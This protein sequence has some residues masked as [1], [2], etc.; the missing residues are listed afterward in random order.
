MNRLTNSTICGSEGCR[1]LYIIGQLGEGGSERQL[2]YLLREL[3]RR[4]YPSDVL[5][6]NYF[7]D[8]RYVE[9]IRSLGVPIHGF[10]P[11]AS[12]I[13]KLHGV[14]RLAQ[15]LG[16]EVIHS[17]SFFTNFFAYWAALGTRAIALGSLRGDFDDLKK[18][19]GLWK[20]LLSAGW[21][22]HHISNSVLSA[23]KARRSGNIFSPKHI[24]VV[25]N[26]IDLERFCATNE[27]GIV[28]AS[29]VGIGS[30]LPGKRWDR[31]LKILSE[32]KRRGI[33]C[34]LRIA[35]DGPE[36]G[37]LEKLAQDIGIRES[38][39]FIG[40][41]LDV[42]GLLEKS[43]FLVHTSDAEGCPNVVMEAMACGR[44]VI[45]TDAGDIPLLV[46][47]GM[48]GFVIRHGDETSFAERMVRMLTDDELCCRMGRAARKKAEKEFGM[49]ALVDQTLKAYR[50][51]GWR[52][53]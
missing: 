2:L 53:E 22:A 11:E 48:N 6:W 47:E 50:T 18:D 24:H 34:R 29:I 1:I 51:A 9:E 7:P 30:L 12:G 20:G 37:R 45:A 49:R 26:G 8:D 14:R 25:P 10:H 16:A 41:A 46:E 17:F 38:V 39:E 23:E 40:A 21:P 13:A 44:P 32:V 28:K 35:G 27:N 5:V 15:S 43:R 3:D 4:C 52:D 33:E 42:R 19:T 36:R 31:L